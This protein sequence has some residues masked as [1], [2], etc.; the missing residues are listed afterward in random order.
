MNKKNQSDGDNLD[1]IAFELLSTHLDSEKPKNF[2]HVPSFKPT[3]NYVKS[4]DKVIVLSKCQVCGKGF[5]F[6]KGTFIEG[7]F[8]S[9]TCGNCIMNPNS[10]RFI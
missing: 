6:N 3:F 7:E 2:F 8:K 10:I 9:V 4:S 5:F 1:T